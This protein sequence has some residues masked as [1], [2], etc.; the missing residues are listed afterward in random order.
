MCNGGGG[1]PPLTLSPSLQ[2]SS[3]PPTHTHT[4]PQ[5]QPPP[6]CNHHPP[7]YGILSTSWDPRREGSFWGWTEV[8]ANVALLLERGKEK[9]QGR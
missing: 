4:Q 3:P 9:Q 2:Q 5:Q 6:P 1:S 7:Q 8:Q